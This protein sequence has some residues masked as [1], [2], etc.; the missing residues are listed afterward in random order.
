VIC[1][2][3]CPEGAA[4]ES[5]AWCGY[6]DPDP[7]GGCDT[8]PI[9]FDAIACG[10]SV[11]GMASIESQPGDPGAEPPDTNW[12]EFEVV[13]DS[14]VTWRVHSDFPA[15][16]S[17]YEADCSNLVGS[18][19]TGGGGNC[20]SVELTVSLPSDPYYAVVGPDI[21]ALV[22]LPCTGQYNRFMPSFSAH[23]HNL[24]KTVSPL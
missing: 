12:Y 15:A 10:E 22:W 11:C 5:S 20:E 17:I 14:L 24:D 18:T 16:V 6:E 2:C 4:H 23:L 7:N 8:D 21:D 9:S 3:S 13:S 1:A 19:V